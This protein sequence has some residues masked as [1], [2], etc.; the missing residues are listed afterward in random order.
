[1]LWHSLHSSPGSGAPTGCC[2]MLSTVLRGL[3]RV[4]MAELILAHGVTWP[5]SRERGT[6]PPA[7]AFE[8]LGTSA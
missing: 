4:T 7:R 8:R 3:A 2:D 5:S 6:A 1:M